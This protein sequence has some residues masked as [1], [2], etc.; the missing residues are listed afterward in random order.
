MAICGIYIPDIAITMQYSVT[1]HIA[2]R[3]SELRPVASRGGGRL[4]LKLCQ[5]M[6][7][8]RQNPYVTLKNICIIGSNA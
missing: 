4:Y 3:N 2:T 1:R 8:A 5:D 6:A 7:L